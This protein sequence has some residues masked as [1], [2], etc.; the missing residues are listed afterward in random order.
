MTTIYVESRYESAEKPPLGLDTK[1]Q[2]LRLDFLL[3]YEVDFPG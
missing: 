1:V 2:N 3:K